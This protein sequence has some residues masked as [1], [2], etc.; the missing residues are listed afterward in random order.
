MPLKHLF[1]VQL[2][3]LSGVV[4]YRSTGKVCV[5]AATR[6]L[7]LA[8]L[9]S[10][11]RQ[12]NTDSEQKS[13]TVGHCALVLELL[14]LVPQRVQDGAAR[15]GLRA[16]SAVPT[17]EYPCKRLRRLQCHPPTARACRMEHLDEDFRLLVKVI[18]SRRASGLPLLA[19][20]PGSSGDPW[21][22]PTATTAARRPTRQTSGRTRP[23]RP[24]GTW[25]SLQSAGRGA[26]TR[27]ERTT[28]STFRCGSEEVCLR[29]FRQ[30]GSAAPSTFRCV[31]TQNPLI[32][33]R[34]TA[35]LATCSFAVGVRAAVLPRGA[36]VLHP[37]LPGA[38]QRRHRSTAAIATCSFADVP[39]PRLPGASLKRWACVRGVRAAVLPRGA[40]V[41]HPRLSGVVL[42]HTFN[43][44]LAPPLFQSHSSISVA[45]AAN[46][47]QG[48]GTG[49]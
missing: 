10:S 14:T 40:D 45:C 9:A 15:R 39:H 7:D 46:S 1:P 48:P 43:H 27:C 21:P 30:R 2:T 42:S 18:N 16:A 20:S 11:S 12:S 22:R 4:H 31:A 32:R 24:A 33:G 37:R 13:S 41:L 49:G 5:A 47:Q 6:P 38:L 19:P 29:S 25:P 35:A 8:S 28:P 3:L 34:S 17:P 36:D 26:A 23:K 44:T